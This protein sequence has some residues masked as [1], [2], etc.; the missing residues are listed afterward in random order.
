MGDKNDE[1]FFVYGE[2]KFV[3]LPGKV[4]QIMK[5]S[6]AATTI[7][8]TAIRVMARVCLCSAIGGSC[9]AGLGKHP[10]PDL[11]FSDMRGDGQ[12]TNK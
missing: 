12:D 9:V 7:L 11:L 3:K 6:A 8:T 1:L 4:L 10:R 5:M 2:K